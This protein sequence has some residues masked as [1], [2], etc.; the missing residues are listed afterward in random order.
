MAIIGNYMHFLML[1][2][3]MQSTF[4]NLSLYLTSCLLTFLY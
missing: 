3:D 4:G 2:A 1:S